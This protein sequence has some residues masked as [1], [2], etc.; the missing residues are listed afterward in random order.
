MKKFIILSFVLLVTCGL[1]QPDLQWLKTIGN[2]NHDEI[3]SLKKD[4]AGN[5]YVIGNIIGTVD[6]DP[7]PGV[8]NVTSNSGNYQSSYLLKLDSNG[9]FVWVKCFNGSGYA[10]ELEV[11]TAGNVYITGLFYNSVD[12]NPGGVPSVLTANSIYGYGD[13]FFC[14]YDSSGNLLWARMISGKY[15]ESVRDM[16]ISPDGEIRIVGLFSDTVDF[17]TGPAQIKLSTLTY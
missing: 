5:N 2:Y 6:V 13:I 8:F 15:S 12:L 16:A 9:N 4:A 17:D 3:I 14:K 7:G 11:D 1:A 10:R